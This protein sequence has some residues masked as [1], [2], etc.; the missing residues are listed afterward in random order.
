MDKA[1]YPP[2]IPSWVD[3][4]SPDPAATAAFYGAIFGWTSE[5]GPPEAGGYRIALLNGKPV[6]GI[7]PAMN[8]GPPYWSTY[9]A[10]ED[11]DATAAKVTAAG[12]QVLAPPMDVMDAGRMAV[13]FDNVGAAFSIWQAKDMPGAAVVNEPGAFCWNELSTRDIPKAIEFYPAV[14]GW[15]HR[16][17]EGGPMPYTEWIVGGASIA[18]MMPTPDM[19]PAEVPPQWLVYFAVEDCDATVAQA[20]GLGATSLFPPID[21]PIGRFS[22]LL[23]PQG[24]MFAVIALSGEGM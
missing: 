3:I 12:G 15:E 17:S 18:G 20:T 19:V 22:G 2:G 9:I 23:D 10:V 7:G 8:P 14:F 13:F 21:I 6:A 4:G 11:A 16:T 1:S 24:A 5:E